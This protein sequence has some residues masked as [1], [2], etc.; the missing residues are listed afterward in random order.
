[1]R[2]RLITLIASLLSLL[3][4]SLAAS[5]QRAPAAGTVASQFNP[6]DLSGFW[7][8]ST[9]RP[10]DRPPLTPAG[11]AAMKGRVPDSQARGGL[12]PVATLPTETNDPIYQCNPQGF[13]RLVWDENEPLEIIMLPDRVIQ[14]FQWERTLRELWM[15]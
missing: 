6:R 4:L 7:L 14:H 1:M 12:L 2:T 15:D 13:P 9:V 3:C 10:S 8:R 5:V 11:I